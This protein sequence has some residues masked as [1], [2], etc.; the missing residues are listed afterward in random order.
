MK[1]QLLKNIESCGKGKK[2]YGAK[3]EILQVVTDKENVLILKGNKEH[4]PCSIK[5]VRII[6]N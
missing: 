1:V 5:D 6:E 2:L 4:F 3:D